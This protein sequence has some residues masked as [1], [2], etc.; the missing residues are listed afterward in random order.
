MRS[1]VLRASVH[2]A[3]VNNSPI[4]LTEVRR[5][6]TNEDARSAVRGVL[7][8]VTGGG[9]GLRDDTSLLF[10]E[11]VLL[12]RDAPLKSIYTATN[13]E[14]REVIEGVATGLRDKSRV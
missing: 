4:P 1:G 13:P 9:A 3:V 8:A 12:R 5:G 6:V 2:C 11:A 7:N 14:L 10:N